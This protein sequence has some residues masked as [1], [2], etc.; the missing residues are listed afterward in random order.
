MGEVFRAWDERL[1]RTVAIKQ[2]RLDAED[3]DRYE[4]FRREA[5]T[6]AGLN[7]ATIVQLY[8]VWETKDGEWI[9]MEFV[10]GQTLASLLV[11]GPLALERGLGLARQ[12]SAGLREAHGGGVIH[13]DLKTEN[14]MVTPAQKVKILDFGLAKRFRLEGYDPNEPDTWKSMTGRIVGTSRAMSPE[15]AQGMRID[16][17][18]DFFSLGTLYYEIF[19]GTSPFKGFSHIDT[20][21]RVCTR[22]QVPASDINPNLPYKL[23]DL[24]DWMLQK[25]PESRPRSAD[26]ILMTL[27]AIV[28]KNRE[29]SE[30]RPISLIHRP[31]RAN[32][33]PLNEPTRPERP[34]PPGGRPEEDSPSAKPF[35]RRFALPPALSGLL[36]SLQQRRR[37]SGS[38]SESWGS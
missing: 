12:I 13:R 10:E 32:A 33:A 26:Q 23:V 30:A 11:E 17:R 5:R 38:G 25:E 24:I 8:D 1:K 4:R 9:V 31:T 20:L 21:N 35:W 3:P 19:T 15:Q 22:D 16:Y 34:R 2:I 27:D 28:G 18:S 6:T 14:I 7:H 29:I 37:G 36:N